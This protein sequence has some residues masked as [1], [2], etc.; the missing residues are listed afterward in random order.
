MS[1]LDKLKEQADELGIEYSPRIGVVKLQEKIQEHT[2][3]GVEEAPKLSKEEQR[4]KDIIANRKE[5]TRLVRVIVTPN[6]PEKRSLNGE[7][8]SVSNDIVSLKKYVPFGNEN[9]W[10]IPVAIFKLLKEKKFQ[11]FRDIKVGSHEQKE[12]SLVPAYNIYELDPLTEKEVADLAK[13]QHA[14][15][16]IK[17]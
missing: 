10:H 8:F 16:S 7:I 11:T 2:G 17:D 4:K 1:E 14:R 12:G 6:Q 13:A 9:G 3:E 5:A 15:Q